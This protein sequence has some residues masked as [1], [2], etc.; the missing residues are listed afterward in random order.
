M[1]DFIPKPVE[2]QLLFG[3]VLAWLED[4]RGG[5]PGSLRDILV[6]M[7]RSLE[8]DG[9]L[10]YGLSAEAEPLLLDAL[11]ED[12]RTLLRHIRAFDTAAALEAVRVARDRLDREGE[13]GG[14]G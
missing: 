14:S 1:D 8:E 9:F 13:G 6:Q 10:A 11:G 5:N 7:E 3:R 12:G 2:P 4:G